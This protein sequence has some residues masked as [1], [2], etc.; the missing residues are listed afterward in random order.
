LVHLLP[1]VVPPIYE[2]GPLYRQQIGTLWTSARDAL[3]QAEE[4][5]I[6]GYSF[7]DADYGAR[8]LLRGAVHQN[9][10]LRSIPV[11]DISASVASRVAD[12]LSVEAVHFYRD[13]V[14]FSRAQ[15]SG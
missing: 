9:A 3:E 6:F 14:A 12:L 8:S 2:K 4:L 10:G 11:I 7:P 13:A 5:I 15:S 1:L